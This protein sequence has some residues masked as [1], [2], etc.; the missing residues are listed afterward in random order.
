[1]LFALLHRCYSGHSIHFQVGGDHS[2]VEGGILPNQCAKQNFFIFEN[3][4]DGQKMQL[5]EQFA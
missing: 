1:M 2:K 5:D 3:K 4:V